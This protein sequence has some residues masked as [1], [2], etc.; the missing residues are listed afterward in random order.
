LFWQ[1]D[2]TPVQETEKVYP[3]RGKILGDIAYAFIWLSADEATMYVQRHTA[4]IIVGKLDPNK[5]P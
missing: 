4:H 3:E 2:V 5:P 1:Y